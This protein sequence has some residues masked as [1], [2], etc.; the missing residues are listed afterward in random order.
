MIIQTAYR[1]RFYPTPAQAAQLAQSFGCGRWIYN[2]GLKERTDAFYNEGRRVYYKD[3]AARLKELKKAPETAWLSEV[4]SVVLQQSLRHLDTAFTKFFKKESDYPTFKSKRGSQSCTYMA[5]AFT[6]HNEALTL[7]KQDAPLDIRWSRPLPKGAVPS[8]VTVTRTTGDKFYVSFQVEEDR[9]P[10]PTASWE[11]GIDLNVKEVVC[12]NGKRYAIPGKLKILEQRKRRY[13]RASRRKVAAA[14]VAMGLASNA[15]LLKGM[16]LPLSNNLKK[17]Y[18]KVGRVSESIANVRKDW[19]QKLTTSIVRENQ[20][21]ALESL[22]VRGMTASAKGSADKPGSNVKAK[23][24]LN[25]SVL[26]AG[27][28]EIARQLEYKAAWSGRSLVKIDR[29]YPSSKRC[30]CCGYVLKKLS[31]STRHWLCPDCGQSHDRDENA[32]INILMAG[33]AI[34]AGADGLR[35]HE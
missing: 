1:Y 18:R 29:W 27:F 25:R 14:K 30:S 7:A 10:L 5:N 15:K 11:V 28:G 4:S 24:G 35:V 16:R 23:S 22:Y 13:Q 2:W 9:I 8:S 26:N 17:A 32:A 21:I 34:L 33:K 6:F 20:T 12:S 3:L 19:Q 31:L